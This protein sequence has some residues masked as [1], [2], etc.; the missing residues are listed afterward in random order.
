M[1]LT[2]Q[3]LKVL[4]LSIDEKRPSGEK[5]VEMSNTKKV[6]ARLYFS[7]LAYISLQEPVIEKWMQGN[8]HMLEST[9]C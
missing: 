7:D 2:E 3:M 1:R 9:P 8:S 5:V 4:M 6:I